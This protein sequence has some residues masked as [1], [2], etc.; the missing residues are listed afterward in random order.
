VT[1]TGKKAEESANQK[2]KKQIF[3]GSVSENRKDLA[4]Q[5]LSRNAS[6]CCSIAAIHQDAVSPQEAIN[7][8]TVGAITRKII[9]GSS[10]NKQ[11]Y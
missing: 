10:T 4:R 11:H 1:A 7:C 9:K 6:V 3:I 8:T 2:K 5:S